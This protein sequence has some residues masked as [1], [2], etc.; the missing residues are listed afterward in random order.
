MTIEM[1]G[2]ERCIG[3]ERFSVLSAIVGPLLS[4]IDLNRVIASPAG[5]LAVDALFIPLRKP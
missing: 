2:L 3:I 1:V 4:A 5:A